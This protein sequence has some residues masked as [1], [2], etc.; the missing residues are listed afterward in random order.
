[1]STAEGKRDL[2]VVVADADAQAAVAALLA[3]N[4]SLYIREISFRITRF[5]KRDSGCYGDVHNYLR[6]FLRQSDYAVVL[7]DRDGCGRENRSREQ[8]EAEVEDR[9]AR[10]GWPGRCAAIVLDPE[11]EIWVWSKSS[12]VPAI[13]GWN[14]RTPDLW[15]WLA[16]SQRLH[17]QRG[18]P[19]DPKAAFL[20]ALRSS[21]KRPSAAI[22][23]ELGERVGL[24][25]CADEAF[26]KFR[27]TLQNWFP[28]TRT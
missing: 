23:R 8:L 6:P 4:Q 14:D 25:R 26:L 10:N 11:L 5:V 18:K 28:V 20:E 1:M 17:P 16:H 24:A 9:L 27:S 12:H 2:T 7:F 21:G 3:R 19:V 13:L 22:F 15:T